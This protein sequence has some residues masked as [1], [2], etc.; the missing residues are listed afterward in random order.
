MLRPICPAGRSV[1]FPFL[2]LISSFCCAEEPLEYSMP[3]PLAS[4]SLLLD[5]NA[6]GSGFIAV[7]ERG[8]ILVSND[9]Q[10]WQQVVVP[11]RATLTAVYFHDEDLGWAVGHDA[12]ILRTEDG[13]SN[14]ER[15][16]Y[17]PGDE[18]PLLDIWFRDAM[19]G[20]AVGAYG[21]Y[22]VS[23]DGGKTWTRGQLDVIKDESDKLERTDVDELTDDD[24]ADAYDLHLNSFIV[25]NSGDLYIAAEAGRIYHSSD[26]GLQWR[27]LPSPYRGS[28]FGTLSLDDNRLFVFGLR[29]HLFR[30]DNG[31]I[32]WQEIETGTKE[33]LTDGI[34]LPDG[35]IIIV[36]LG[37]T[38]L[39]SRDNGEG[40]SLNRQTGRN[41]YSA[42]VEAETGRL[43]AVGEG[44][45]ERITLNGIIQ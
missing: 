3:A 24:F 10:N 27:E 19:N 41:G 2:F 45:I 7:G 15:V 18:A 14:W 23:Q 30:S 43:L 44:G 26:Q 5:I 28:F 42:V 34:R 1:V 40:F 37:G 32:S 35:K 36:G 25:S 6:T 21:L 17:S 12:V 8:H 4:R 16:F 38:V 29:G 20:I 39:V 9:G 13:G 31:G 33:M 11:T 22:L